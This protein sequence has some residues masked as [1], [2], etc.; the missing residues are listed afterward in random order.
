MRAFIYA[1]VLVFL[2]SGL[3][4]FGV[5]WWIAA[6][7][8]FFA[9]YI[10]IGRWTVL[11]GAFLGAYCQWTLA[12]FIK[13]QANDGILTQRIGELFGGLSSGTL[14][15]ASALLGGVLAMLFA[16]AGRSLRLVRTRADY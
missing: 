5:A 13:H 12:A 14:I 10:L 2:V 15:F 3:S 1:F 11:G 9:G 4:Y 7:G 8:G 16:W 6:A